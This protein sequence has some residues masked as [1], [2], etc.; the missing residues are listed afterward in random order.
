[1][2]DLLDR[3]RDGDGDGDATSDERVEDLLGLTDQ[4]RVVL[5]VLGAVVHRVRR[6][7]P[8]LASIVDEVRA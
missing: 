6:Q 2:F 5:R 1:M 4:L 7:R 8:R 3:A